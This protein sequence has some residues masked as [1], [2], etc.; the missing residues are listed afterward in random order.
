MRALPPRWYAECGLG[1][2]KYFAAHTPSG[3]AVQVSSEAALSPYNEVFSLERFRENELIHGRWAMLAA[4]GVI[5]AEAST[6]VSWCASKFRNLTLIA[7]DAASKTCKHLRP[8]GARQ[9]A[10][11]CLCCRSRAASECRLRPHAPGAQGGCR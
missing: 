8:G 11:Q 3:A 2:L 7:P 9:R 5:V 1:G 6:G 10:A 4:L